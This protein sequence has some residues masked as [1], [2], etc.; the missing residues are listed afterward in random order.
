M[1]LLRLKNKIQQIHTFNL[2]LFKL[3]TNAP[4]N[5]MEQFDIVGGD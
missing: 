2:E 3:F 4:F 5:S 1:L